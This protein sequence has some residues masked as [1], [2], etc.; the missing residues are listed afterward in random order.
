MSMHPEYNY[1]EIYK[2]NCRTF[3]ETGTYKGDGCELAIKA[4]FE[5]II[6]I[7]IIEWHYSNPKVEKWLGDSATELKHIIP[8]INNPWM[9]WLDGHSQLTEDEP[10]NF[11]LMVELSVIANARNKPD[12]ILIDDFLY[13]SHPFVTGFTKDQIITAVRNINPCYHIHYL[14]NPI[15]NNIL[16]AYV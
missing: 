13:M 10:D 15:K 7:D 11:P 16:V 12:V 3:V 9:A 4:G 1:F 8:T 6:T 14:P 2:A 5:R